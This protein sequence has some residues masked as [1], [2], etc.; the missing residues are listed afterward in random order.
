MITQRGEPQ[1]VTGPE[2]KGTF[3]WLMCHS[4]PSSL[5]VKRGKGV[6]V[7][8]EAPGTDLIS[9]AIAVELPMLE[10]LLDSFQF[11]RTMRWRRGYPARRCAALGAASP[12][13]APDNTP[14]DWCLV[15]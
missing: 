13:Q 11:S 5:S 7:D 6:P 1:L 10:T 14:C 15:V 4:F 2:K 3:W 12:L 9:A 8:G